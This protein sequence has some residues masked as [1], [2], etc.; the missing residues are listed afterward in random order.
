MKNAGGTT[1]YSALGGNKPGN[2]GNVPQFMGWTSIRSRPR[3][4]IRLGGFAG[5]SDFAH[6]SRSTRP[7]ICMRLPGELLYY[8]ENVARRAE[9]HS[10]LAAHRAWTLKRRE[11]QGVSHAAFNKKDNAGALTATGAVIDASGGWWDAGDYM[12]LVETHSYTV[13]MMLVGYAIFRD[14]WARVR[15]LRILLRKQF[16][17]DW[18]QKMWADSTQDAVLPGGC[19]FGRSKYTGDHDI[20]RLPQ[21]DDTIGMRLALSVHLPP[22]GVTK[23]GGGAG[24]S[25]SPNIAGRLAA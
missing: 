10:E 2:L 17:L 20:W 19:G 3:E 18:L 13:A 24:A 16:G 11:R 1:V 5:R 25:I 12:K 8:Y 14:R 9:L 15:A 6:H 7:Q 21:A 4:R 23:S 22:A